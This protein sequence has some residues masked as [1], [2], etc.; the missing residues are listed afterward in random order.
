MTQDDII[1]LQAAMDAG[2][3]PCAVRCVAGAHLYWFKN[4]SWLVISQRQAG[5]DRRLCRI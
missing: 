1:I 4:W 3:M 2:S 5:F